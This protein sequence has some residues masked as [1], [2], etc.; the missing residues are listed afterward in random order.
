[1]VLPS[2]SPSVPYPFISLLTFFLSLLPSF[3]LEVGPLNPAS[4]LGSAVFWLLRDR[5][6]EV[7]ATKRRELV[8][9]MGCKALK[10]DNFTNISAYKCLA[11]VYPVA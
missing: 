4:G 5:F 10:A 8:E 6:F 2:L 1:M 3:P 9:G 11:G 7:I